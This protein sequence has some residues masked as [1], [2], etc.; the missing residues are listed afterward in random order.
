MKGLD[1][2]V[3]VLGGERRIFLLNGDY[4][5]MNFEVDVN[6]EIE[7][8]VLW[9]FFVFIKN[10]KGGI[11]FVEKLIMGMMD[12]GGSDNFFY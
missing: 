8:I 5:I 2:L 4:G 12:Y 10:F 7:E 3:V 11:N 1:F 9:N 6:L